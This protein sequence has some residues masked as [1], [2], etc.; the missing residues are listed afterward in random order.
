M[1]GEYKVL[2][3]NKYG[4]QLTVGTRKFRPLKKGE[5]LIKIHCTTIHPS[6]LMFLQGMYGQ[7]RPDIFPIIPGFEGSGEIVEVAPGL[8]TNL[9]G[10]RAGV[11]APIGRK[12]ST[13]NGLWAEYHYTTL[14]SLLVYNKSIDY[15]KIAFSYVNPLTAIGFV[16]TVKK[17]GGNSLIQ[18]GANGALGKM[19]IRLCEKEKIASIN[20]IRK[21]EQVLG[22]KKIGADHVISTDDKNWGNNLEKIARELNAKVFFDCVGGG[23]SGK[24]LDKLPMGTK[25]YNFGNLEIKPVGVDSAS[26]IFQDKKVEGWWMPRWVMSLSSEEVKKYYKMVTDDI[27]SGSDLFLT[28]T[29]KEFSLKN[30]RDALGYYA[31][32]MSE[33]KVLLRPKF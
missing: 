16:D 19:L 2:E 20:I 24:T 22:L 5:I 31:N 8:P 6:D 13:Y 23:V 11:T 33:G 14:R 21:N 1:E 10:H 18:N 7:E 25:M 4:G 30:I 17:S 3:L 27:E 9:I 32:N 12:N 29:S 26:L 28:K 15:E